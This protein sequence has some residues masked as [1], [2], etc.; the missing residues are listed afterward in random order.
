MR[1]RTQPRRGLL[2][3]TK[4]TELVFKLLR[5]K[6]RTT[7]LET[8]AGTAY[9][10]W[11]GIGSLGI[12]MLGIVFIRSATLHAP[13]AADEWRKQLIYGLVGI[14]M[15]LATAFVDYRVWRRWARAISTSSAPTMR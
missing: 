3:R 9:V 2:T 5:P 7:T 6:H 12:T 11:T 1:R 8:P 15:M 13:Y 10:I 4:V 14:A